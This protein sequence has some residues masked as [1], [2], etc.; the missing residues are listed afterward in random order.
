MGW[1]KR[2]GLVATAVGLLLLLIV[3]I[4][5][6]SSGNRSLLGQRERVLEQLILLRKENA[7]RSIAD[8]PA[9][10]AYLQQCRED[11]SKF[12]AHRGHAEIYYDI[13]A[14]GNISWNQFLA[15]I[16]KVTGQ[17]KDLARERNVLL[18]D[19]GY[20]GFTDVLR[21]ERMSDEL[22]CISNRELLE[23]ATL[24]QMLFQA[25][26]GDLYFIGV[27]R[28]GI[29]PGDLG[30]CPND[31]FDAHSIPTVR[32]T[33]GRDT[34]LFRFRFRCRT[35]TFRRFL[36]GLEND[37]VPAI[38]HSIS[39]T[40]PSLGKSGGEKNQWLIADSRPAEFSMVLE[41]VQLPPASSF[42]PPDGSE[43]AIGGKGQS[44]AKGDSGGK[45]PQEG[46]SGK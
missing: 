23:V 26:A 34:H 5:A 46:G 1:R 8:L 17:L 30:S 21:R 37:M 15:N 27:E 18:R 32:P 12:V 13:S 45:R 42:S 10:R 36:N 11:F 22:I 20:F 14:Q 19:D 2:Y 35:G 6:L 44:A 40:V 39:V 33:L 25:S 38:P 9:L 28:E 16:S 29:L 43:S 7:G 4:C 41:W 24:V 31:F 3:L